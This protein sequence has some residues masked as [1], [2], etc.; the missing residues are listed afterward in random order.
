MAVAQNVLNRNPNSTLA[1][2]VGLHPFLRILYSRFAEVEC[3]HCHVPVRALS[4]EERLTTALDL[5]A[6]QGT[7]DVDVAIVRGLVGSHARLL[8]GVRGQFAHVTV[9]GRPWAATAASRVPRLDPA[10]P[11]DIVVRVATLR[12]DVS[13]AE[14]RATLERADALGRPEVLLGG[15]PVLRA[16]ICPQC[17]AWVRPLAP[18]AFRGTTDTSSHRI[19]GI[20]FQELI[21]RSVTEVLEFVA[22]ARRSGR[23]LDASRTS[24]CDACVRCKSWASATSPSTGRCRRCRAVRRNVP[25][26]RSCSRGVSKTCCTSSTSRPSGCITAISDGCSTPSSPCPARC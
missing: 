5:L 3:P 17:G 7:L 21:G 4:A 12:P 14:V 20:T 23:A 15:T 18:S 2:S 22:A 19:A 8:A 10:L 25:G 9:D 6:R 26:S 13:A 11:H 24:C 16:P 1:T